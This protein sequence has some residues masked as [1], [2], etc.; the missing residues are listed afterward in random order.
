MRNIFNIDR[1]LKIIKKEINIPI[2]RIYVSNLYFLIILWSDSNLYFLHQS[3]DTK[4][5]LLPSSISFKIYSSTTIC[6]E[7]NEQ[8]KILRC[9]F[10]I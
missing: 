9:I 4:N 3:F 1:L 7:I 6:T 2:K 5:I 10:G 8:R